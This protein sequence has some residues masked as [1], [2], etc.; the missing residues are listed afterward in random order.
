MSFS[1][2]SGTSAAAVQAES[3]HPAGIALVGRNDSTDATMVLNNRGSGPLIRAFSHGTELMR[4]ENNGNLWIAGT[5]S[6][7]SDRANKQ[8]LESVDVQAVL[9]QLADLEISS[10]RYLRG[11]PESR[12]IGPMAQDFHAAFGYGVSDD[13]ISSIDAQGIAFAA[14]QALHARFDEMRLAVDRQMQSLQQ[15]NVELRAEVTALKVVQ[16][17][18][19]LE[20]AG[21][22]AELEARLAALESLLLADRALA[23][24]AR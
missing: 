23:D 4:L 10:W 14:I 18:D 20:L 3:L 16:A 24:G 21:R 2:S 11:D 6:Q 19:L 5:L 12:H 9:D 22:N 1:N 15:E 13:S 7:G 8:D 17:D